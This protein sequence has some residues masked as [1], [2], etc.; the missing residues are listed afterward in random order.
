MK[1]SKKDNRKDLDLSSHNDSA[2]KP[3]EA[4]NISAIS[5]AYSI[6]DK[7]NLSHFNDQIGSPNSNRGHNKDQRQEQAPNLNR[8]YYK[9]NNNN[10][11]KD[12]KSRISTIPINLPKKE[13]GGNEITRE[14]SPNTIQIKKPHEQSSPIFS[15]GKPSSKNLSMISNA[16]SNNTI[17]PGK[18]V[19]MT[20]I[21]PNNINNIANSNS[22]INSK[23]LENKITIKP[24][25]DLHNEIHDKT[26]LQPNVEQIHKEYKADIDALVQKQQQDYF[27]NKNNRMSSNNFSN[28]NNIYLS[29]NL[30]ER[31]KVTTYKS[32]NQ[33]KN[34]MNKV[35]EIILNK[36]PKRNSNDHQYNNR[37]DTPETKAKAGFFS[38]L[39]LSPIR[40]NKNEPRE[41]TPV[42]HPT[43][44]GLKKIINSLVFTSKKHYNKFITRNMRLD[45]GGVIDFYQETNKFKNKPKVYDVKRFDRHRNKSP[46]RNN[47][48][49]LTPPRHT[50]KERESSSK[51]IQTWWRSLL[52]KYNNVND[53]ATKI[54]AVWRGY[55]YRR[56]L[57]HNIQSSL[58]T[59]TFIEVI[60][61][62]LNEGIK[63]PFEILKGLYA[64]KYKARVVLT[65]I[66]SIQR[67]I[68]KMFERLKD[69]NNLLCYRLNKL[70]LRRIY[71]SFQKLVN[72]QT[73]KSIKKSKE[74]QAKNKNEEV[75]KIII[76]III[77]TYLTIYKFTNLLL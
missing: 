19:N 77:N 47:G 46:F 36:L 50:V 44:T 6:L 10:Q 18:K 53:K 39:G 28:N 57:F 34:K 9:G 20:T 45:K 24:K 67:R 22:K 76:L 74:M 12:G 7:M 35:S 75:I 2:I 48:K 26:M 71:K 13:N 63:N 64:E 3:N 30:T 23:S 40:S 49:Q 15:N 55:D 51:I 29:T 37:F 4:N 8:Y 58:R 31:M 25:F 5:N 27:L 56:W 41:L 52:D 11:P 60:K 16:N 70:Y 38:E 73:K 1:F 43:G 21:K 54:Q 62:T 32:Q 68:K 72:H 17:I 61:V 59:G 66:I 65:K 14:M 69:K 42:L 33:I